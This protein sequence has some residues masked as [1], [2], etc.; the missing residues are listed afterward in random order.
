M[1]T[2]SC[3]NVRLTKAYVELEVGTTLDEDSFDEAFAIDDVVLTKRSVYSEKTVGTTN[4]MKFECSEDRECS[5]SFG[6]WSNDC[7]DGQS[8]RKRTYTIKTEG[9]GIYA[10]C[11]YDDQ[12]VEKEDCASSHG[13]KS[14]EFEVFSHAILV[15]I[16]IFIGV[17]SVL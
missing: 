10:R 4:Y 5:G 17:N 12:Y 14:V 2:A 1:H 9:S 7:N 15:F 11:P 6:E 16:G 8:T 13:P 3:S